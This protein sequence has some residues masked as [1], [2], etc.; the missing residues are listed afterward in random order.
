MDG[1]AAERLDF[2]DGAFPA[3]LVLERATAIRASLGRRD[4]DDL[5]GFFRR[6]AP[7]SMARMPR[8]CSAPCAGS[9]TSSG[10]DFDGQFGRRSRRAE[11]AFP[12]GAFLVT[13]TSFEPSIFF[14]KEIN[15]LLPFQAL[16]AITQVVETRSLSFGF[17][18]P[19]LTVETQQR[20]SDFREQRLELAPVVQ[21]FL[22]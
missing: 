21:P 7:P 13:Q 10:I 17:F 16:R 22:E 5:V 1:F 14:P 3:A 6:N 8:S 18:G 9:F 11:E 15:H 4:D 19:P 12:G 20:R 2:Q